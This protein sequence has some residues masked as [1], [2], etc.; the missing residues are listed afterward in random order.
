K[1]D[2][3][4]V[5]NQW[6][7]AQI[8]KHPGV[9][10]PMA[11]IH[12]ES[13]F[14]KGFKS[15]I[16]GTAKAVVQP[17]KD[18]AGCVTGNGNSCKSFGM[19]I[20]NSI[21]IVAAIKSPMQQAEAARQ[22]TD[23]IKSGQGEYLAGEVTGLLLIA[24]VTHKIGEKLGGAS[25]PCSNSFPAD[26]P[27]LMADGTTKA[28]GDIK[29]DDTVTATDPQTG[30]TAPEPVT[31]KIVT[32][33]DT[34][35]TQLTLS[36]PE[37]KT[38]PQTTNTLTSTAHHPYWDET[39]KTWTNAQDLQVGHQLQTPDH[40]LVVLL[41]TRTY[42]TAPQ[43]AHNLTVANLHTYYVLAG[44][45]PV[46]V[47]NINLPN[48]GAC[49]VPGLS[50]HDIPGGSSG[51]PGA[52]QTIPTTM[53]AEYGTGV[54]WHPPLNQVLCSYCRTN[55]AVPIDHVEPR[56]NGGDLTDA[57]TTPAC[58]FCNSSKRD[59]VAPLNPP[60]NYS[61]QWPPPWWP[62]NMQGTVAVPRV[63]P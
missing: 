60:P 44:T 20:V 16:V 34:Q 29:P 54:Q 41:A 51:G 23:Q 12:D 8:T 13:E 58:T 59:R 46:L 6:V 45:T 5:T 9:S 22:I 10:K 42:T 48:Q 21:P 14:Y 30:K 33:N 28:I 7:K 40:G 61:G 1:D 63:I 15:V 39:T 24:A 49:S 35:F 52:Y 26:T 18:L 57:N 37:G 25:E 11:V 17:Y 38:S 55:V 19:D 31:A 43:T 2:T 3:Q 36:T 53:R 62:A 27:V 4:N 56:I 50:V 32:P 47:H